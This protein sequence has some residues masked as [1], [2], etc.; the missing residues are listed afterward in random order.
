MT[1]EL[2][3]ATLM[4]SYRWGLCPLRSGRYAFSPSV[5]LRCPILIDAAGPEDDQLDLWALFL[6]GGDRGTTFTKAACY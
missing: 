5:L 4:L 2:Q 1:T 6:V 3:P